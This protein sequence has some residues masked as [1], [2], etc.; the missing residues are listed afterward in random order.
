MVGAKQVAAVSAPAAG[1]ARAMILRL[2]RQRASG[3]RRAAPRA[4]ASMTGPMSVAGSAGSPT[5]RAASAPFRP[6]ISCVGGVLRQDTACAGPSS[7]GRREP[8]AEAMTSSMHLFAQRGGVDEHGV[9]AAGLGDEGDDRARPGGERAVD[10]PGRVGAA[11]EGDAVDAADGRPAPR[12]RSRR[13]PGA[14]AS[15]SGR[16]P[17]SWNR[18]TAS[19]AISG[20]CSAGL[21]S[22]ALPAASAAAI[23]PVKMA[24]GKFHGLMQ[25]KTPRPCSDSWLVS[26]TGPVRTVGPPNSRLGQHGVVAAEVDGLAHL[27]DAVVQRLAGLARQQGDQRGPCRPRAHRPW[28]AAR[29]RALDA[30]LRGPRRSGRVAAASTAA[31]ISA[32]V[33]S[34]DV[35]EHAGAVDGTDHIGCGFVPASQLAADDRAGSRASRGRPAPAR[36]A[37][38]SRVARPGE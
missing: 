20:V 28:R 33:A 24:S 34:D 21:A 22:T 3:G 5:T 15:R 27:G 8:K 13:R 4:S 37:W 1:S 9:Q 30:A 14:R 23:W 38:R 26:P 10:R 12:R 35:A 25:A 2:L 6:S 32:S 36:Q 11:G 18:R 7:A 19:A 29:S 31:S 16:R 17:A